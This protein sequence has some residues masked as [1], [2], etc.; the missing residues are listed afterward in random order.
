MPVTGCH[1]YRKADSE[2]LPIC[3]QELY[4]SKIAQLP[5]DTFKPLQQVLKIGLD[6]ATIFRL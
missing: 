1:N 2:Q 5:N 6:N 4:L 3:I